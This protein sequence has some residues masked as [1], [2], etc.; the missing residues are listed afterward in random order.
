MTANVLRAALSWLQGHL[1]NRLIARH[2]E[3]RN[4][5]RVPYLRDGH[6]TGLTNIKHSKHLE[7]EEREGGREEGGE[8][9]RRRREGGKEGGGWR[10]LGLALSAHKNGA[11]PLHLRAA[12]GQGAVGSEC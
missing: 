2:S 3:K 12:A 11:S 7:G 4:I 8:G 5:Q 1:G 6:D 9:G 10:S